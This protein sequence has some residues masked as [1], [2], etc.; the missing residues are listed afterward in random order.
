MSGRPGK[1]AWVAPLIGVP[2]IVLFSYLA[3]QAQ[4]TSE[5]FIAASLMFSLFEGLVLAFVGYYWSRQS[6]VAAAV[7]GAMTAALAAVA[8]WEVG[9][10]TGTLQSTQE[11]D[12]IVD[13]AVSVAWG[14]FAGL[15]G[16]TVLHGR[17]ARLMH[18][19]DAPSR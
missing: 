7:S 3:T 18:D 14:V 5:V 17:I 1:G 8:R 12:L 15:A 4:T 19:A 10:L 2:L 11:M 9:I 13:L 6:L 16:A